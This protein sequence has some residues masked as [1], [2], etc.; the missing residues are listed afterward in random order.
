MVGNICT[1]AMHQPTWKYSGG[2]AGEA[3]WLPVLPHRLA[4]HRR[5]ELAAAHICGGRRHRQGAG[6]EVQGS[7]LAREQRQC[8]LTIMVIMCTGNHEMKL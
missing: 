6:C 1:K 3:P 2:M 5:W 8:M 7:H 4:L